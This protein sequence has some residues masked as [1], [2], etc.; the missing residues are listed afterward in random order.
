[1]LYVTYVLIHL[2]GF[3]ILFISFIVFLFILLY[4]CCFYIVRYPELAY[5]W[6]EPQIKFII[7]VILT[8]D[9]IVLIYTLTYLHN[10]ETNNGFV[11]FLCSML[12]AKNLGAWIYTCFWK[13][14]LFKASYI[15]G[16][17]LIFLISASKWSSS[18]IY[19]KYLT[20]EKYDFNVCRKL[21]VDV[22][23]KCIIAHPDSWNLSI[24]F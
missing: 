21:N 2:S 9:G 19:S 4:F 20:G 12:F 24:K 5:G 11:K 10:K 13:A 23:Y 17:Y 3:V 7:M 16:K 1:M 6:M 15:C 18:H 8:I 22:Y 14:E